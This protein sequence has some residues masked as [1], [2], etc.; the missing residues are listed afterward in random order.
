MDDVGTLTTLTR[1][2]IDGTTN[3]V[4]GERE[5]ISA[6]VNFFAPGGSTAGTARATFINSEVNLIDGNIGNMASFDTDTTLNVTS[7]SVGNDA[8]INGVA[9]FAA[10][11]IGQRTQVGGVLNLSG[12]AETFGQT[13][14]FDG[15]TVNLA[16]NAI[17][18]V[19][20]V[21]DAGGTLNQTGGS[22][23]N[24][25]SISGVANIS[26]GTSGGGHIVQNGGVLNLS[27][28]DFGANNLV[29][30]NG[31]VVN[32]A[33]GDIGFNTDVLDGGILNVSGGTSEFFSANDG[34]SSSD[35]DVSGGGTVN[36][37]G[38]EFYINYVAVTA[39][40]GEE[41]IITD[42]G[43]N[44]SVVLTGTL[45][46]GETI[47]YDLNETASS[48]NREDLFE[49][50]SIVTVT[51]IPEPTSLAL[52]SLGGLLLARRRRA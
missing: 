49:S 41:F 28:G 12:T 31:G 27:G 35:L 30:E 34:T 8:I 25:L 50:G 38:T 19:A 20:G 32:H 24:T 46:D 3:S 15:A 43:F 47:I 36:F 26:G 42:R 13:R 9:T 51:V 11:Q 52:L 1:I 14:I 39:A 17:F 4:L 33:G 37:F 29:I 2:D 10:G 21:L 5:Y 22:L 44:G 6:E 40:P 23:G 18:G 45:L 7:G 48:V 16:D